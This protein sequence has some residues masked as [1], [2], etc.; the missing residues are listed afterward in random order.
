MTQNACDIVFI[1]N[2][3]GWDER[4]RMDI[5]PALNLL[6]LASYI[7]SKGLSAKIVDAGT[8]NM[9]LQEAAEKALDAKPR[10]VGAAFY[11]GSMDA[12]LKFCAEMKKLSPEIKIIGGGPL[13]TALSEK[14]I[15]YPQIDIGVIGEGEE[16]LYRLLTGAPGDYG[17][18]DGIAFKT[19]GSIKVNPKTSF[20]EN[21]DSL[22][23]LDYSLID[24]QPYFDLQKKLDVPRSIFMTTSRGCA[25]R[26]TYCASPFL[27]PGRVRRHSVD[28]IIDE[29]M[30]H[31]SKFRKINIGFLDDSFFADKKWISEFLDKIPGTG[32]SYSCIGR[33]DHINEETIGRLAETGCNFVSIG[34][35]TGSENKQKE[36]KKFLSLGTVMKTVRLFHRHNI[37]CRCFFMIGFPGETFSEMAET[38]NFAVELKKNGMRDCTFFVTNLYAGT[39][40]S[41]NFEEELWKTMIYQ[42][43]ENTAGETPKVHTAKDFGEEKFIRYSSVPA[44]NINQYLTNVQLVE[45]VKI[46]YGKI[47]D[48]Q[49]ISEAEIEALK[50]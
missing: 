48:G 44:V 14:V 9:S 43:G 35:E 37:Y 25:F 21:L 15:S 32:L 46:A 10:F 23:F 22:P 30:Y 7:N 28:R 3:L 49:H 8:G 41:K 50:R 6:Y 45:L 5:K 2:P 36:L 38:I 1:A 18:I 47:N 17:A 31:R 20:I 29:I 19:D 12:V 13:M 40:M 24:M 4:S 34:V 33:A 42:S 26:C 27:W 39:E 11:Q 16:T